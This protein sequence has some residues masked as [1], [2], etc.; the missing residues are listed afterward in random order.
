MLLIDRGATRSLFKPGE[1]VTGRMKWDFRKR[2]K[3]RIELV[4]LWFTEGVGNT[5]VGVAAVQQFSNLPA[6][7]SREFEF[8]APLSPQSFRGQLFR[9][10]WAI[11]MKS[12]HG[13][14]DRIELDISP[15]PAPLSFSA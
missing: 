13:E 12:D 7:G 10:R 1:R 4:L 6:E 3:N 9:L 14:L 11:E 2:K 5:D 15:H 8:I